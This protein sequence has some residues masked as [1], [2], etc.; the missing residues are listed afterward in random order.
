MPSENDD[1]L[2]SSQETVY[3]DILS[4]PNDVVPEKLLDPDPNIDESEE[5]EMAGE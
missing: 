5:V 4:P 2:M 3:Q 1:T